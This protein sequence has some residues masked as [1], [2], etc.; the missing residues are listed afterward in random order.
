MNYPILYP[1]KR[2]EGYGRHAVVLAI[3]ERCPYCGESHEHGWDS[4]HR[5]SHCMTGIPNAGYELRCE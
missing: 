5:R 2:I 1:T 4:G 3:V